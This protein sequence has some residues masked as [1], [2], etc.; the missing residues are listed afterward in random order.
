MRKV[1]SFQFSV[2]SFLSSA[3]CLLL[4]AICLLFSVLCFLPSLCYAQEVKS[5]IELIENGKT[6]DGQ[7]IAYEGEVIGEVMK[8]R[9]GTW[10][11]IS[12]GDNSLGV[13]MSS[14]LAED[15]EHKGSYKAKGDIFQVKGVFNYAC[16]MHGGD[17]DIHAVSLHKIKSGWQ[18]QEKA[19]L[20]K[21]NLVITLSVILC[22]IL[23]LKI[24][25]SK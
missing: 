2:F 21:R 16:L 6:Y 23:I 19:I 7:E 18:K 9:Q 8:R 22:L 20:A 14:D 24:L 12:D 17:L 4:S 15:I 10:V 1:V 25:I 13:W 11:N 5:S 3:F